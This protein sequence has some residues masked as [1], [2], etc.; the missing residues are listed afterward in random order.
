MESKLLNHPEL[1]ETSEPAEVA[2]YYGFNPIASPVLTKQD[3]DVT[4]N[5]DQ[6]THPEEKAA[7]FRKYVEE[8]M[9]ILP[10]P[11]MLYSDRPFVGS[12]DKRKPLRYEASLLSIGSSRSVCECLSIQTAISILNSL[13]YK[14][15]EVKVNS[16]GDKDSMS[17]FQRKL[18][19]FIRKNYNSFTAD[20]RQAIKKD[21]LV[22]LKD[23]TDQY[24]TWLKECPKPIDFLSESS[25]QHFK[26]VLEFLEIMNVPYSIDYKLI[27]DADFGS[28]TVY[29]ITD[30][31]KGD[32]LASG[33]RF[34]RLA[35]KI[36][37]KRELPATIITISAKL[38]KNLKRLK[39]KVLR[40]KFYLV[41]FGQEAKLKSFIVIKEMYKAKACIYH[42]IAK[43]KLSSQMGIA[44]TSGAE[45][46]VLIGQKEALDNSVVIRSI[47]TR[48]QEIVPIPE[49]GNYLKNLG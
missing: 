2:R 17:E 26:E 33:F 48:S 25:R 24:Q 27:G 3:F 7:I 19:L 38:K 41:Q 13:G 29:T 37:H 4:K 11:I 21:P 1:K 12:R 8:K 36:G 9:H 18:T 5:F 31:E 30:T 28:E 42:A 20:L 35:K 34:N 43:D 23:D 47:A 14:S 22:I 49:L 6:N 15:L 45:Y 44:E 40:P 16:V 46:L 32:L 39:A 10:Q